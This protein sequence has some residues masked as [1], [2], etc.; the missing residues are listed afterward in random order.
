MNE[1][2]APETSKQG[3]KA[4]RTPSFLLARWEKPTLI[5]I[6]KR[7][8][9]WVLPD[10]LTALGLL[11]AFGI[12]ASYMLSNSGSGWLWVASA[13]LVVN[14]FGDSLDG[15]LAR[16]RKIERPKYGYYL[17]HIVDAVSITAIGIGMGLSPYM[18]LSTGMLIVIAYLILSINVYLEAQAMGK[19]SLGYGY[20]GPTEGRVL[21]FVINCAL[22]L[23]FG[24]DFNVGDLTLTIFDVVGMGAAALMILALVVRAIGNLRELAKQEPSGR[25]RRVSAASE[26][27]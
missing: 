9:A 1:A 3:H 27:E 19:F 10:Y 2:A 18:L 14:W 7:L 23:G 5:W 20:L 12:G 17:D 11:A 15:T 21:L 4:E 24:L 25:K 8:P 16:V 22:A 6:A 13:L 26:S